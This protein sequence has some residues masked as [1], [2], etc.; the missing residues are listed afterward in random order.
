MKIGSFF[1]IL[2]VALVALGFLLSDS[3]HLR[4]EIS[5]LQNEIKRLTQAAQQAEQEKQSALAALHAASQD[6]QSCRQ[7]VEQSNQTIVRLT[8][9]NISLKEQNHQLVTQRPSVVLDATVQ[10]QT[11]TVQSAVYSSI[12][13]SVLGIGSVVAAGWKGYKALR[14]GQGKGYYV[15]LTE[16]EK[17]QLIRQRRE[18]SK[19]AN[20]PTTS[21]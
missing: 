20:H 8:D 16:A 11:P 4:E 17:A 12:T 18:A 21:V 14:N 19:S 15:Y 13:L 7:T 3:F 5:S 10:P 1:L 6:L 2:L 9:E